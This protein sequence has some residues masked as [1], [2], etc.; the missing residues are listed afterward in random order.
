MRVFE[1][2]MNKHSCIKYVKEP[3]TKSCLSFY[4]QQEI[5]MFIIQS[6]FMFKDSSE[7][8]KQILEKNG[9]HIKLEDDQIIEIDLEDEQQIKSS[10]ILAEIV[11]T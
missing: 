7:L 6:D 8:W 5:P 2:R 11:T 4:R 1:D 3:D 9:R 10:L